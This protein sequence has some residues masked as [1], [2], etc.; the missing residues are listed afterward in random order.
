M[1]LK[2]VDNK[3]FLQLVDVIANMYTAIDP[4]IN[5]Y[6]A[7]NT[8][9]H[10]INSNKDF[11]AIGLYDEKV[12]VGCVIGYAYSPS[13]FYFTGIYIGFK[14]TEW[15]QKL[16]EFSFDKIKE[17]GYKGYEVDATNAN[18]SSIME[19]YGAEVKYT[20]YRKEFE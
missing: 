19:K 7:V 5:E 18:I 2:L 11:L 14:S 16:I 6:Q 12:L 1:H 17:L 9:V 8:L 20:R 3:D 15:T 13:I 4:D 10:M